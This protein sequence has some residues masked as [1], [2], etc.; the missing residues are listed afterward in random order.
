MEILCKLIGGLIFGGSIFGAIAWF[1]YAFIFFG[2][3]GIVNG[4]TASP[5]DTNAIVWDALWVA[6]LA[7]L[8]AFGMAL[9]GMLIGGVLI[10]LSGEDRP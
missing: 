4:A 1:F 2:I 8:S 5:V 3:F 9:V 10:A 7:E 6:L